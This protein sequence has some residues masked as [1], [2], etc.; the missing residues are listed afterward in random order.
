MTSPDPFSARANDDRMQI[1]ALTARFADAANRHDWETMAALHTEDAVWEG[2][3]GELSFRNEGRAA[4][5][6]WLRGNVPKLEVVYYLSSPP[7]IEELS[8]D[9]ARSRLS[10]LELLRVRATGELKHIYGV[11]SDEIVKR[12]GRWLF[13]RRTVAV[14]HEESEASADAG[15]AGP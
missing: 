6:A 12:D 1:A 8:E 10:M 7:H 3:A 9:R 5:L 2:A 11:Y 15:A 14:R 13:A 4:I